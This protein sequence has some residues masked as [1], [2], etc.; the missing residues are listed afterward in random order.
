V[1]VGPTELRYVNMP[2][3]PYRHERPDKQRLPADTSAIPYD[4]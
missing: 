4:L 2:T 3:Q 1:N